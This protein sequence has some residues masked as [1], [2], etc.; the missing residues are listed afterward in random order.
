MISGGAH[1]RIASAGMA[2]AVALF[3]AHSVLARTAPP[4]I[5]DIAAADLPNEARDVLVL[6]RTGGPH[7]YDRDGVVFSNI[8]KLLPAKP[9][10]YY[11]EY[12]VQ[13]PGVKGRGARRIICGGP[14]RT[15]DECFYTSDHYRTYKR[16]RE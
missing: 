4:P 6:V 11:H 7:R 8:E 5:P 2:L 1:L 15:P 12:T 3:C 10:G 16:I 9:K 14:A 13:T